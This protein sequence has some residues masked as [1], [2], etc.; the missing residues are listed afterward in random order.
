MPYTLRI[1]LRVRITCLYPG[2]SAYLA[3]LE[4]REFR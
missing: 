2:F 3:D 4:D 1:R